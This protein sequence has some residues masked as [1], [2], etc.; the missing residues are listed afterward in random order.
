MPAGYDEQKRQ[1]E[2]TVL[3]ALLHPE[4]YEEVAK[5]TRRFAA[6][7]PRPRAVLFEGPPGCGK[8]T[9]ARCGAAAAVT[10][11]CHGC[12]ARRCL[13]A[14][15][16]AAAIGHGNRQWYDCGFPGL[17]TCGESSQACLFLLPHA[18]NTG[19]LRNALAYQ[20]PFR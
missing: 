12:S 13:R 11:V 15:L 2:D 5:G 19:C 4:V 16:A 6:D 8:T 18:G 17:N 9:S 7:S 1:I 10:H 3:L 20:L 14:C